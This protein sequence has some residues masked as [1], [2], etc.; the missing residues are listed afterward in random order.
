MKVW[1]LYEAFAKLNK[2]NK[3]INSEN[4]TEGFEVL[5]QR[6]ISEKI[7]VLEMLQKLVNWLFHLIFNNRKMKPS[8]FFGKNG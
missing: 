4:F 5:M 1:K 3:E 7:K 8:F 2:D 6:T